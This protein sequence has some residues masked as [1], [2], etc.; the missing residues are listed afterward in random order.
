MRWPELG[1]FYALE[2][3]EAVADDVVRGKRL[4]SRM[5]LPRSSASPS[6]ALISM[7]ALSAITVTS[8][9]DRASAAADPAMA[10]VVR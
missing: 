6:L 3:A 2:V 9:S 4:I 8:L 7:Y 1:R 5:L 10:E